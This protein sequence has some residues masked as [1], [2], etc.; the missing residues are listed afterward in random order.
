MAKAKKRSCGLCGGAGHNA[1]TCPQRRKGAGPKATP[2]KRRAPESAIAELRHPT[3]DGG[4]VIDQLEARRA[5][6][7]QQIESVDKLRR[8]LEVLDGVVEELRAIAGGA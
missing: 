8:E 1:R 4:S 6:L 7:R 3:G 2:D 5:A